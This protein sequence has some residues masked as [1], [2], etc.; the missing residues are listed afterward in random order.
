MQDI[1]SGCYAGVTESLRASGPRKPGKIRR[2]KLAFPCG[3]FPG[4][5]RMQSIRAWRLF[6]TI[7]HC[8]T[9]ASD[10]RRPLCSVPHWAFSRLFPPL[11]EAGY[12]PAGPEA[13]R[14][15][16]WNLR[17]LQATAGTK[18]SQLTKQ[19]P[20]LRVQGRTADDRLWRKF[21][22]R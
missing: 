16:V 3:L 10:K 9:R 13:Q 18:L 4:F 14:H 17:Y 8:R 7:R 5:P 2:G 1:S 12:G 20:L 15:D 22:R 6:S 11:A 19:H 21:H